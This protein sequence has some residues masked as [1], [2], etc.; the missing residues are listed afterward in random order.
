[1]RTL[2]KKVRCARGGIS[3]HS[4]LLTL[5]FLSHHSYTIIRFS[6]LSLSSHH[7]LPQTYHPST[8]DGTSTTSRSCSICCPAS[9]NN[10]GCSWKSL[11]NH[12]LGQPQR[13]HASVIHTIHQHHLYI[14]TQRGWHVARDRRRPLFSS[15]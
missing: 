1:M 14:W 4:S 2:R 8:S 3:Q 6:F 5:L 9:T 13:Q 10:A 15:R 11:V 7:S 12:H